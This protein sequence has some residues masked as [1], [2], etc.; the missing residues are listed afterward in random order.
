[1]AV[2][3]TQDWLYNFLE[4]CKKPSKI[5]PFQLQRELICKPMEKYF[6]TNDLETLHFE[7][8]N[9]GLFEPSEWTGI[10]K[11]VIEME[12][13]RIWHSVDKEYQ[14]LKAKWCGPEASIF[15][16]PIKIESEN[17]IKKNGIAYPGKLLLF[18]STDLPE[19]GLK[20]LLAHEY[21][22]VCRFKN[23]GLELKHI[24]LKDSLV[25]EGLGE[26]SVQ[27]QYG[28]KWLS[29]WTKKYSFEETIELWRK[30]FIPA[31][32]M[33]GRDKQTVFMYGN[34]NKPFPNWIGY[35]IGYQIVNS[36]QK[37]HGPFSKG[38]LY[39]YSSDEIIAGS[40][41]GWH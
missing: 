27:E 34:N 5:T 28:K 3:Q 12:N 32:N 36:F 18:I 16:F 9:N 25:I 13:R 37:K 2:I 15:I 24:P 23:L 40:K 6:S 1:M 11:S 14:L 19:Y 31:L 30:Y 20:S 17:T 22:H 21:N 4:A 33:T 10:E 38:E 39:A 41:Y 8:L 7:L 29:P 35:S 26:F